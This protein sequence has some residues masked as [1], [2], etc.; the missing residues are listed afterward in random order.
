MQIGI[1]LALVLNLHETGKET[2]ALLADRHSSA[3]YGNLSRQVFFNVFGG[4][5]RHATRVYHQDTKKCVLDVD[6]DK[7]KKTDFSSFATL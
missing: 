2:R 3:D 1:I 6:L 4:G 5:V 7:S